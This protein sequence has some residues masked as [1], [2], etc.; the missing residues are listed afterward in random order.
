MPG[1]N[2]A[3]A[4]APNESALVSPSAVIGFLAF[5]ISLL[6]VRNRV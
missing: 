2:M 5:A 3:P 4:P 6:L 1:M